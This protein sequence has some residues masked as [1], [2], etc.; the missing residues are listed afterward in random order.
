MTVAITTEGDKIFAQA[1]NQPRFEIFPISEEEFTVK[2]LNAKLL[3]VKEPDGKV[4]KFVL[5][6]GGQ[7]KDVVRMAE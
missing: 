5:D 3:F 2:E 6:M 7:K 4:S 1:T